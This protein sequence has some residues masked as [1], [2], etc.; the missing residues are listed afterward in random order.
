MFLL[1]RVL[2]C[3]FD[4]GKFLLVEKSLSKTMYT[5]THIHTHIFYIFLYI[6]I[7]IL[8]LMLHNCPNWDSN[9]NLDLLSTFNCIYFLKFYFCYI[10]DELI[11][12]MIAYKTGA[13]ALWEGVKS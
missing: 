2:V 1:L 8:I 6:C 12:N 7:L 11:F 10:Y 9:F 5:H 3:A 13:H 4:S